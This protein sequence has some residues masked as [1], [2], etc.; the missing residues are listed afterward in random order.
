MEVEQGRGESG[1]WV[2]RA[3]V[4]GGERGQWVDRARI[5][6]GRE[7]GGLGWRREGLRA[8]FAY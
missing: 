6:G 7:G 2:G 3:R 8:D 1:Q 4:R 5:W